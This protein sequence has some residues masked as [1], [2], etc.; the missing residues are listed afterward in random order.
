MRLSELTGKEILLKTG[1]KNTHI[2]GLTADSRIVKPGYLFAAL[3]GQTKDGRS[4][5]KEALNRGAS[6]FLV[7]L[8]TR[9]PLVAK[10]V[11]VIGVPNPR[12]SLAFFA[13]RFYKLQPQIA[14]AVTGTN[15]KTSVAWFTYQI[16]KKL[17]HASATMGTL[18]TIKT[19]SGNC[20]GTK[21]TTA[22]PVTLHKKLKT[23]VK[24]GINRVVL[25]ASSHGLEQSRL[26]GVKFLAAAFT[27]ISH[28]HLDYHRTMKGYR[29]AKLRLF[30]TVLPKNSTAVL[31]ADSKDYQIFQNVCRERG[32]NIIS[33]GRAAN[34][35]RIQ[36]I[37][38]EGNG[39]RLWL[40]SFGKQYE[41]YLKL[42]GEFQIYNALTALGLCIACGDKA[43]DAITVFP[44]LESPPGR[45][46][47]I[48][49]LANGASIY[50]DYAH[51]PDALS[52]LLS[53]LRPRTPGELKVVFGC[54]GNR[55]RHK[56]PKMGY[57][58]QNL[59]DEIIITD[60]NP[61]AESPAKIRK[62]ILSACPKGIEIDDRADAIKYAISKLSK[63]DVL[64]VTGKGHEKEQIIGDRV[65]PFDDAAIIRGHVQHHKE[66]VL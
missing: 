49:Q 23:F 17:G 16:W 64:V 19:T 52:S 15:G 42:P 63:N 58:A 39:Q 65:L 56:R 9:L 13:S 18:G 20:S 34:E 45:L 36:Q 24:F 60:D 50:I 10:K 3:P 35:I 43:D 54:G 22:D 25:E 5:I 47:L 14:A 62:E 21:L 61:R 28:D 48:S 40:S 12:R 4:F 59:A 38:P 7:P 29:S 44:K 31:N 41:L 11:P 8:G 55:D 1:Q 26:D 30:E 46:E 66:D 51:T 33:Y 6:A 27:N 57:I 32:L 2:S 37:K 53:A